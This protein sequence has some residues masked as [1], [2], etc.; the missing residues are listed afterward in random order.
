MLTKPFSPIID[1]PRRLPKAAAR[2]GKEVLVFSGWGVETA[3]SLKEAN[4]RGCEKGRIPHSWLAV[5]SSKVFPQPARG[6]AQHDHK[7]AAGSDMRDL[8]ATSFR[9]CL[10]TAAPARSSTS[11]RRHQAARRW[12]KGHSI[13]DAASQLERF[14]EG[15]RLLGG[16][17]ST[18]AT[19]GVT[20]RTIQRLS[21]GEVKLH[22]G[23]LRDMASALLARSAECEAL[24]RQLTPLDPSNLTQDQRAQPPHGGSY[25]LRGKD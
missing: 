13:I 10:D 24:E 25:H 23:F 9:I 2:S 12:E 7:L 1:T 5:A 3:T 14:F 16:T 18:A 21:T 22:T 8:R 6:L 20:E 4:S 11:L 17:R 19:L 15:V